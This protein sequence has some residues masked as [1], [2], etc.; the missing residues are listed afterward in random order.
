[1]ADK[2]LR[3]VFVSC[4]KEVFIFN[5]YMGEHVDFVYI[6]I[7]IY[8]WVWVGVCVCVCVRLI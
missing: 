1:M 5:I 7:Y 2:S 3:S 8:V 4:Y 6:Y